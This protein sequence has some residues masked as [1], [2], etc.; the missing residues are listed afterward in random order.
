M[1][2]P[3][4]GDSGEDSNLLSPTGIEPANTRQ[5]RFLAWELHVL[6][7]NTATVIQISARL[8]R[9]MK[10]LRCDGRARLLLSVSHG[11]VWPGVSRNKRSL[12]FVPAF[13]AASQLNAFEVSAIGGCTRNRT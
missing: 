12:P 2:G 7:P 8:W 1:D 11:T 13:H 3:M 5:A 6:L 9:L 4:Y 10:A